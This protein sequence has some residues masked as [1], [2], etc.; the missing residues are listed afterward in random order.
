MTTN[1]PT[2]RLS[3]L[4]R[5]IGLYAFLMPAVA[6]GLYITRPAQPPVESQ[7]VTV[8]PVPKPHKAIITGTPVHLAIP[9]LHIDL[10]VV[11]GTYDTSSTSWS[12][13]DTTAQFAT[14]TAQ[15]S[16]QPGNTLIYGHNTPAV[17]M[18][19][20]GLQLGDTLEL[21]TDNGHTFTYSYTSD[22]SVLPSDTAIVTAKS[23]SPQV[24]LL[25]CEGV[26]SDKRRIMYFTL[27]GVK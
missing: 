5:V 11:N 23:N 19:T 24:A 1:H 18:P 26:W 7:I 13:G 25:T 9:R 4:T 10:S 3:L 27:Q 8:A 14:M 21:T 12:I 16:D 20:S 6:A 2:S 22:A 17:L 15:P